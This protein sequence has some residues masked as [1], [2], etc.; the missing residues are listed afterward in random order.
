MSECSKLHTDTHSI[1]DLP[2]VETDYPGTADDATQAELEAVFKFV[3][4]RDEEAFRIRVRDAAKKKVAKERAALR[5]ED[6][7]LRIVTRSGLVNLPQQ[8]WLIEGFVVSEAVGIIYGPSMAKKSFIVIDMAA[9]IATGKTSFHGRRVDKPYSKV[10]YIVG[11]GVGSMDK[12]LSGWEQENHAPIPEDRLHLL[13]R[14]VVMT[15]GDDF[16]WLLGLVTR[17]KY[18]LI[19]VDTLRKAAG[20]S[21]ENS[22]A[23]RGALIDN[24][25][26]LARA[27]EGTVLAVAH[28]GHDKSRMRGSYT[29]IGDTDFMIKVGEDDGKVTLESEKLKDD[30]TGKILALKPEVIRLNDGETTLVLRD[31][32]FTGNPNFIFSTGGVHDHIWAY[33]KEVESLNEWTST[34]DLIKDVSAHKDVSPRTVRRALNTLVDANLVIQRQGTEGRGIRGYYKASDQ[35]WPSTATAHPRHQEA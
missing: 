6:R 12:R 7:P 17:E 14:M 28:P 26:R 2:W 5:G 21:D 31:V 1:H 32:T 25:Y 11:E 13:D 18:G 23:E 4:Q 10:L 30:E 20:D 34:A 24:M 35:P 16:D 33:L 29:Q 9:C 8:T 15:D 3:K 19:I 22:A 27:S